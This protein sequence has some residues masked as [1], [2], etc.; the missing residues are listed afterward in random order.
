MAI[1]H[2]DAGHGGHDPGAVG[3][4]LREKD[5]VLNIVKMVGPI[6][7]SHGVRV[8]YSRTDDRF[9]SLTQIAQ[10]ANRNNANLFVSVHCNAAANSAARGVEVFSY[11]GS[12]TGMRASRNVLNAILEDRSLYASNRGN[13]TAYFTVLSETSMDAILIETAFI[14]NPSDA[15]ILRNKQKEF[16]EKIAKGILQTLNIAY[17]GATASKPAETPAQD[18]ETVGDFRI[19]GNNAETN[20]DQMKAWAKS[21]NADQ[22]FIDLAP[23]FYQKAKFLGLSPAVLYTQAAKETGYFKFGGVLDKS[24]RNTCGLKITQGGGDYERSA[25]KKFAS[26]EDG[27]QAHADHLALYAGHMIYPKYNVETE[28][29]TKSRGGTYNADRYK[30]NG[31]TGDP[32]HFPYLHGSACNVTDLGG[33]WAPSKSYGTDILKM[34]NELINTPYTKSEEPKKETPTMNQEV[35]DWAVKGWEW[36]KDKGIMDGNRP[37]ASLTREEMATILE[38]VFNQKL[39]EK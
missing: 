30:K 10:S 35:S 13:K 25:H 23:V 5:I 16:A 27:I 3:N 36:C 4:G 8:T 9:L 29:F 26:W 17:K 18:K 12:S 7:I 19:I 32:R 28:Q 22:E 37:K 14:S 38:R 39:H 33:R 21:K 11:P 1:V 20:V 24:F 31:T 34:V 6:L 2:L 15:Q